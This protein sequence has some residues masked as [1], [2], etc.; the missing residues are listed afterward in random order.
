MQLLFSIIVRGG[1]VRNDLPRAF[2]YIIIIRLF[3]HTAVSSRRIV[4]NDLLHQVHVRAYYDRIN[5]L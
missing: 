1:T 5:N 4:R 3:V 2:S